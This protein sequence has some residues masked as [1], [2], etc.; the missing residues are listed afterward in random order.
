MRH[1]PRDQRVLLIMKRCEI[2]TCSGHDA[3]WSGGG[4][5]LIKQ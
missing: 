2:R 5:E 4:V 3:A 1:A